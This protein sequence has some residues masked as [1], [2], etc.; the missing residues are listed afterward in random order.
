MTRKTIGLLTILLGV[1]T[2][3]ALYAQSA[4]PAQSDTVEGAAAESALTTGQISLAQALE[5]AATSH[6]LALQSTA[7]VAVAAAQLKSARTLQ[8]PTLSLAQWAGHDTG[9]LDEDLVFTQ[10]VELGGKRTYRVRG[11]ESELTAAQYDQ[12]STA[13][14]L[15][16]SVQ[17]AY[18]EALR[19][20]EAYKLAADSL[21]VTRQFAEAAQTQYQAGD[22]PRSN[23][24]RSQIELTNAEQSLSAAQTELDNRLA[25]L[26]SLIGQPAGT[27]ITLS[28]KLAYAPATCS[29]PTMES[30]AMQSRPE[31]KA[32]EA[33]KSSLAAA[34]QSARAE[35]KPDLFIE[36]RRASLNPSVEGSSIRVGVIFS[37]FDY[38]R[39]RADVAAAQAMVTQQDA[40]IAETKRTTRLEVDT[41]CRNL[42]QARKT[43]ESFEKGRLALSKELLDMAQTGYQ[44][45]ASTYLE[46]LDAQNVFRNEQIAY[47][48]AIADYNIA[49]ATLEH[50]VGGKL[51]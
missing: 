42:E 48:S 31:L 6:P 47:T 14:D 22:V 45:G 20:Q 8:N 46:V 21:T 18:Y 36:G 3:V 15:R 30:L 40:K 39:K 12:I 1:S 32:A 4:Q 35:T 24:V 50:A 49:L 38:G 28:D 51:P 19:A 5:S 11:A 2:P 34:V 26:R 17:T 33:T 13:L 7:N 44:R 10:I 23:V 27:T 16:F 25:T 29:Q 43:V 9:G 41:A 37:P